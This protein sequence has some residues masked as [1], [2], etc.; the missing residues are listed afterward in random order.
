M[1]MQD[2]PFVRD[3]KKIL[4]QIKIYAANE[5]YELPQIPMYYNDKP[6]SIQKLAELIIETV[7]E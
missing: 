3:I 1:R 4:K 5:F 6:V 2:K 7:F